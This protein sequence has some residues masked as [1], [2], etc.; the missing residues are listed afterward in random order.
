[1]GLI[2]TFFKILICIIL[3]LVII[4]AGFLAYLTFTEFFPNT[5]E[6]LTVIQRGETAPGEVNRPK[7]GY[8][9]NIM[10]WNIGYGDRGDNADNFSDG[11]YSVRAS[12]E[13]R[14]NSNI[15]N[16]ISQIKYQHPNI[17]L[18]Q[19]VD[20][21]SHRS[22]QLDEAMR[23]VVNMPEKSYT[24]ARNFDVPFIPYPIPPLGE[25][26]SGILTLSDYTIESATR[27]QIPISGT[28]PARLLELKPC[29]S[30]HRIPVEGTEDRSLVIINLHL[31]AYP[32]GEDLNE[33]IKMLNTV[34]ENEDGAGNYVIAGGDFNQVFSS[35]DT[36]DYPAL[37]GSLRYSQIDESYFSDSWQFL[38]DNSVPTCRSLDR[39]Y[40][41]ANH[42]PDKF[43]YYMLDGYI[44]SSNIKVL[45]CETKDMGFTYSDHN[46]VFLR[47]KLLP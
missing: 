42:D 15:A 30:V 36:S 32:E 35:V 2:K 47:V 37:E 11:G 5:E 18:L 43:Q 38:M 22:Y 27:I 7:A 4:V 19:E 8:A 44:L 3:I 10:T 25:V 12:S 21:G 6:V 20:S 24:Y 34:M 33:Q 16:I 29:M 14:V 40:A 31:G 41:G 9:F 46:P 39:P 45:K 28:W 13:E 1:M 26:E 23:I 17:V